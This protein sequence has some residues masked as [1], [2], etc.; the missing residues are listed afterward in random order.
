MN[1]IEW[2]FSEGKI[3]KSI[4]E[5]FEEK[6]K[7]KFPQSYVNLV[8]KANRATPTPEN[9]CTKKGTKHVF[10]YLIDW[11][12]NK[13]DNIISTYNYFSQEHDKSIIPF[14]DDPFG[15][16][17]CFNFIDNAKEPSIVFWDHELDVFH[18][19]KDNFDAFINDLK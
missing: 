18:S 1:K 16:L 3:S 2:R 7:L 14:A 15:N 13:E 8:V 5:N 10:N 6:M 4:I 11:D 9:F 17:I 12:E 19:I